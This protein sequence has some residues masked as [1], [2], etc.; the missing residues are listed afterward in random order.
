HMLKPYDQRVKATYAL[1][2]CFIDFTNKNGETIRRL[3]DM[4]NNIEKAQQE[5]PI[6]WSLDRSKSDTILYKGYTAGRKTS[7]VSG[8]PR[9][10]Y[11]RSKP[12]EKRVPFFN[13]YKTQRTIQ[14]PAAYIIPQGWWRVIDL[15]KLNKIEMRQFSKDTSME[16]HVYHI[17]DYKT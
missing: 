2:Q 12:F 10:Y 17:D 8:L 5:F 3:R 4:T 13:Y 1:M 6:S 9:L 14:K 15:L 16:V 11:D 7:E